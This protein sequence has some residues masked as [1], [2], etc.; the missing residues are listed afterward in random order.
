MALAAL[1]PDAAYGLSGPTGAISPALSA[2]MARIKVRA[3]Q[4]LL[5]AGYP[6]AWAAHVTVTT[7]ARRHERTVTHVPGDPARPFGEDDL[8]RKFARVVRPLLDREQAEALFTSAL[9]A[10]DRPAAILSEI[11][12]AIARA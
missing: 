7:R 11:E 1:A 12:H 3:E 8:K 4:S 6:R 5:G 9:A 10:L 2:F